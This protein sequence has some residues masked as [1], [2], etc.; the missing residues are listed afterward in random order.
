MARKQESKIRSVVYDLSRMNEWW[1][2]S[3]GMILFAFVPNIYV[4]NGYYLDIGMIIEFLMAPDLY[5]AI[6]IVFGVQIFLFASNDY[7]DREVDALDP[8]K[9]KRNPVC[10]GRITVKGVRVLLIVTAIVPLLASLYFYFYAPSALMYNRP[11]NAPTS[12][13]WP[14]LFTAFTLFVYYFYTA[15]PL[16]FKNKVGLD[17]LSHGTLINTFP[18]FFCLVALED[19][20]IGTLFLLAILM[21]RSSMAQILQ[22]IRDYEVDKKVETNTVIAIG[23]KRAIW[24]VFSINLVLLSS[25]IVLIASYHLNG[26]GISMY[27]IILPL[28]SL[29]YIPTL[30]KLLKAADY[31]DNIEK[32]WMGQGR[33]NRW[34]IAQY[35]IA[36]AI[37]IP[38]VAYL[39]MIHYQ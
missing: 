33:E 36:F 22:E 26:W 27:Y 37:Y 8:K 24:V 21:M 17:V 15:P 18:Y 31:G 5:L 13:L 7:F 1:L 32:L 10:D 12:I 11:A 9:K 30:F 4:A 34:Q 3:M 20:T 25:S 35:L 16:R 38:I 14:F 6:V 29:T 23:Q 2:L 19:Y 28:L 39:A